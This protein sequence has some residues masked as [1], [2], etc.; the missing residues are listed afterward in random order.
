MQQSSLS[1]VLPIRLQTWNSIQPL[2]CMAMFGSPVL[3][4]R[5]LHTSSAVLH[6]FRNTEFDNQDLGFKMHSEKWN[7]YNDIVY[8]PQKEGEEKRPAVCDSILQ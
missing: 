8:P 6:I 5:N 1:S 7:K 4:S 2:N 3:F